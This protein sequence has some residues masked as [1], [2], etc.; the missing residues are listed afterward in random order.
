MLL[1]CIN[2]TRLIVGM[3]ITGFVSIS[4]HV[5][6][7]EKMNAGFPDVTLDAPVAQF[8]SRGVLVVFGLMYLTELSAPYFAKKSIVLRCGAVFLIGT[9]LNEWLFRLPFMAGYCS[10]SIP[11][12]LLSNIPRLLSALMMSILVVWVTPR[13][14]SFWLKFIGAAILAALW[15]YGLI[16]ICAAA[17]EVPLAMSPFKSHINWCEHPYGLNIEIPAYLSF[18]EPTVAAFAFAAL[19]WN[20]LS[21]KP[22]VRLSQFTILVL[23]I[24]KQLLAAFIYMA[25]SGTPLLSG[26]FA[27]GQF[28]VE[29]LSLG[30]LTGLTWKWASREDV[31]VSREHAENFK[32]NRATTEYL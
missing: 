6:M 20:Q 30:I 14:K 31:C 25:Y 19:V 29:A 32:R 15:L 12:E 10:N 7:Q 9:M 22:I 4:L 1:H 27:M 5:F 18:A 3:V 2:R 24:K 16:P 28:S 17:A 23:L 11:Y 8:F 21:A 13:L 26:L